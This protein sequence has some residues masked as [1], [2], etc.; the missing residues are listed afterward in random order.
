[1]ASELRRKIILEALRLFSL[2]G[3]LSASIQDILDA[4]GASKGGF[5][6]HFKSKEDLFFAVLSEARRIW[7]LN[8]LAGIDSIEK[9]VEKVKKLLTNFRDLYLQDTECLPG[10]CIFLTLSV[11]LDDQLPELAHEVSKGF[12]DLKTMIN[13]LL[14]QGKQSGELTQET[15]TRAVTEMIFAGMLGASVIYGVDKSPTK[16]NQTINALL[17]YLNRLAP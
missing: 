8:N 6:N 5:Y 16:L 9:P 1:M 13:D 12:E 7:R 14:D 3:F 10:G 17:D 15:D 2:K 4:V 11:E